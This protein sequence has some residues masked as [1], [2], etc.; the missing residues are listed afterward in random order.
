M[1]VV[2]GTV[3]GSV[4]GVIVGLVGGWMSHPTTRAVAVAFGLLALAAGSVE[5]FGRRVWFPQLWKETNRETLTGSV[6]LWALKNGLTLGV[7]IASRIGYALW[8]VVP[9]SALLIGDPYKGAVIF[10]TYGFVRMTLSALL[11]FPYYHLGTRKLTAVLVPLKPIARRSAAVCL[12]LCGGLF[13][14]WALS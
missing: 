14:A 6:Q 10:G 9:F 12:A 4:A 13:A 11:L 1:L 3:S 8:Y 2:G 5:A 7:G